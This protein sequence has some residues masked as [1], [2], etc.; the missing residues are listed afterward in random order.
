[1]RRIY[2]ALSPDAPLTAIATDKDGVI[3]MAQVKKDGYV[4]WLHPV[5]LSICPLSL[6]DALC[7]LLSKLLVSFLLILRIL[8]YVIPHITPSKESRL[9]IAHVRSQLRSKT[10]W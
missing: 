3:G 2:S 10:W 6:S 5:R 7:E 1:M 4:P 8:R 9:I